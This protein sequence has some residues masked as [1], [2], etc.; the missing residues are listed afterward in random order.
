MKICWTLEEA[1]KIADA[2][3]A[4]PTHK[5]MSVVRVGFNRWVV[6]YSDSVKYFHEWRDDD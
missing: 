5:P 1:Q 4:N 2:H 3:N 6:V